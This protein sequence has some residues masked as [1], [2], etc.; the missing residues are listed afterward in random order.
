MDPELKLK[1]RKR[2]DSHTHTHRDIHTLTIE[3]PSYL[4]QAYRLSIIIDTT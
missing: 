4:V 3:S 2:N 1:E